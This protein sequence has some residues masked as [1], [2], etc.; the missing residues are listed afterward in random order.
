MNHD[1]DLDLVIAPFGCNLTTT[2]YCSYEYDWMAGEIS[3]D[4]PEFLMYALRYPVEY[5]RTDLKT[6]T[7]YK[8]IPTLARLYYNRNTILVL[9]R[10]KYNGRM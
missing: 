4:S 3:I 6:D 9:A 1:F 7:V 2:L 8:N 5:F 10:G